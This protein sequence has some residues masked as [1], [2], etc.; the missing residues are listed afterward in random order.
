MHGTLLVVDDQEAN[1]QLL[2][3]LL[4]TAGHT[5]LVAGDGPTA[6]ELAAERQPDVILLDVKMPGMDGFEVCSRLKAMAETRHIPVIFVTANSVGDHD[7]VHG[8]DLGGYDYVVKPVSRQVLLARVGVMLRIRR[9]EEKIRQLSMVDEFTGLF[10]KKYVLQRLEEEIERAQRRDSSLVVAMLDLDDFKHVNDTWGHQ[11][12]DWVLQRV[13]ACLK[14]NV[15]VYDSLGRY[16]GE[17]FLLLQPELQEAA[18]VAAIERLREKLLAERFCLD[19]REVRV[20]FSA[21]IAAWA[22][23]LGGE[24]LV[25]RA[26]RALYAAKQGGKN[27]TVRYVGEASEAK[28]PAGNGAGLPSEA[29]RVRS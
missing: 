6:I 28:G 10:T 18:A 12:G 9:S 3:E 25:R 20:G 2:R 21:G 14:A 1:R 5:V 16:G 26:D 23:G 13:A 17:E 11:L 22:P 27:R 24:E 15:R 29:G 19:G 4:E 7:V 8:L